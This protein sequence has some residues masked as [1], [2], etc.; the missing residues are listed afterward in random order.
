M[1][2]CLFASL[3]VGVMAGFRKDL[4]VFVMHNFI[5]ERGRG[6]RSERV[7]EG[8]DTCINNASIFNFFAANLLCVGKLSVIIRTLTEERDEERGKESDR[9]R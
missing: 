5:P 9:E 7:G 3:V 2:G 1:S 6:K 8:R 4:T